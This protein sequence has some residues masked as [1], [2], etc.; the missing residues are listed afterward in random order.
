M[1]DRSLRGVRLGAQSLQSEEGVV[2]SPRAKSTYELDDGTTFDVMF[3]A[4][5]EIP[6]EWDDPR[7]GL[8]GRLLDPK[9][10]RVTLDDSD[11]KVART[12]WD[13]LLERRT[14]AELEV[15]LQER[16]E[17][18]RSRRGEKIGA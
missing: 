2:F 4:D 6:Q 10:K 12:H 5:A 17:Y 13:M 8:T 3:A 18:L 7:S 11:E 9:G 1:A 15:I 14:R 16:L